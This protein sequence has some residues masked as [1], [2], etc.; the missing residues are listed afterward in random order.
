[1][2]D[3]DTG[4]APFREE[5]V[6]D[7]DAEEAQDNHSTTSGSD[8]EGPDSDLEITGSQPR[9]QEN[10]SPSVEYMGQQM[11]AVHHRLRPHELRRNRTTATSVDSAGP[12][13]IPAVYALHAS[14]SSS[15]G[16]KSRSCLA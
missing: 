1:V 6:F 13:T 4:S 7:L 16:T 2:S 14:F 3:V 12:P 10:R 8:A 5:D 9:A 11:T 15:A